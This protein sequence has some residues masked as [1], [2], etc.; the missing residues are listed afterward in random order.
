M[1]FNIAISVA[2]YDGEKDAICGGELSQKAVEVADI[3]PKSEN[4]LDNEPICGFPGEYK[5]YNAII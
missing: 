3:I 4:R 2:C 1:S 5:N